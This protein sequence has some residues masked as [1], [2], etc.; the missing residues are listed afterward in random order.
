MKTYLLKIVSG[1]L[2]LAMI[3]L[4]AFALNG[5]VKAA[6]GPTC[7]YVNGVVTCPQSG[8]SGGNGGNGGTGG[9]GGS[10]GNV[11]N[12]GNGG[13][14][15]GNSQACVPN[16]SETTGYVWVPLNFTSLGKPQCQKNS[17][18]SDSCG[19]VVANSIQ[20]L[21]TEFAMDCPGSNS[22]PAPQSN[23]NNNNTDNNKCSFT[24]NG[25]V[26]S[27]SWNFQWKLVASVSMPPIVI[28]TR[29]YPVTLVNW[30]TTMRVNSLAT[31]SG[32]GTLAYAGWGGGEPGNSKTGD[33]KNI[34]LTLTFRPTGNPITVTLTQQPAF[35]VSSSGGGTK[36][37]TWVVPSHPAAGAVK[38]AV[39]V[40]QLGEIPAD[41][42]LFQGS[43]STTYKL[44][45]SESYQ[46]YS[47]H[48]VCLD[49]STP[50]SS[51]PSNKPAPANVCIS[52]KMVGQWN[53]KSNSGEIPPSAVADLPASINGGSVFND[54]SVV[55]RRMDENGSTSNPQ[56]AHQYSWGSV[57]YWACREGEGQEGWPVP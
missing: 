16:G 28:D 31:N 45:Y 4:G 14:G 43:S 27:C 29:P 42:T 54:Y 56:Y 21:G 50:I 33:W 49:S 30:P 48:F 11:G 40:G 23:N 35:T 3:A 9:S 2:L 38:T 47:E 12:G 7:S 24:Y 39:E 8:S 26:V 53:S 51:V 36:T 13:A 46:E 52:G 17:A 34:T 5:W 57:Y 41:M 18:Q 37:F 10:G 1:M 15:N 25:G 44:Y 19:N 20:S 22:T 55:I 32:S 6:G